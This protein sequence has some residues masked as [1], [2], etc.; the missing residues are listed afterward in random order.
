LDEN[1]QRDRASTLKE[2]N[3]KSRDLGIK[4]K[5]LCTKCRKTFSEPKLIYACPNCLIAIE[6]KVEKSCQYWFG[7]LNQKDKTEAVP[8][9]CVECKQ[10]MECMLSQNTSKDAVSEIRKWY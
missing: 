8:Q 3:Q 2:Q 10:V 1:R 9:E 6:N 7:Y 5:H 4:D